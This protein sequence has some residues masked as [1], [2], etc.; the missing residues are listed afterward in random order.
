MGEL[1]APEVFR[2]WQ[3]ILNNSRCVERVK[4]YR[5]LATKVIPQIVSVEDQQQYNALMNA[6]AQI[7][8]LTNYLLDINYA[9]PAE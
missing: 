7:D 3:A 4:T 8:L 1:V 2:K 6:M 5:V 9:E